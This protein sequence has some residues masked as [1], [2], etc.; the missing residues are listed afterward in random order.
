MT[1]LIRSLL[2]TFVREIRG[3]VSIELA[4][5]GVVLVSIAVLCFDLYSRTEATA[6][7]GRAVV[8][9]ADYV[10]RD[11]APN[12][13]AMT[14]L[15]RFLHTHEV[16]VPSAMVYVISA[17]HQPPGDPLPAVERLWADDTI[18]V[19][20]PG[21]TAELA[22]GCTQFVDDGDTPL[23][24]EFTMSQGEVLIVAEVCVRLTR[25]GSLTGRI[26]AGDIYRLHALPARDTRQTPVPPEYAAAANAGSLVSLDAALRGAA[27][28]DGSARL[29]ALAGA[30]T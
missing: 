10:S 15:G 25:E 19:G 28:A 14:A 11:T 9:M 12:G 30:Q 3:G 13:D 16:G 6:A 27:A 20:P 5:G 22:S 2:S 1:A 29:S 8:S 21:V 7:S 17:F 4:L 26:V 23:P 18:R 24:A